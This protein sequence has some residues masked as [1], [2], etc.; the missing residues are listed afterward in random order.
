MKKILFLLLVILVAS[1]SSEKHF[2]TDPT[3]REKV[4]SD[5]NKRKT[6]FTKGAIFDVFNTPMTTEEREAMEFLYAYMPIGDYADYSGDLFLSGVRSALKTRSEVAWGKD[7]PEEVF[8]HFVLPIRANNEHLDSA[9]T[10]FYGELIDKV[11]SLPIEEAALEV[12]RWCHTKVTYRPSDS[13]TSSPLASMKTAHG[14]CGE[15]SVFAVAAMRAVGIPARQVY[16]PRWAHTDDNHAWIEV[17][18][19]DGSWKYMGACEPEPKLNMGWFSDPV[20]RGMLMHTKA[21]GN[22]FG[23]EEFISSSPCF[24][25]VN[26]TENYAPTAVAKVVVKNSDGSVCEGA[27]VMF[28]IYNYAEFY[29]SIRRI[30]DATGS[31]TAV[32]GC[33]DLYAYAEKDGMFGDA[34]ISVS[35][36]TLVEVILTHKNG[37]IFAQNM[38]IVPPVGGTRTV[39]VTDEEREQNNKGLDAENKIRSD[40]EATFMSEDAARKLASDLS[41]DTEKVLLYIRESRGNW[42]TIENFLRQ[43]SAEKRPLAMALLSSLAMKDL[44]DITPE[45]LNDSFVAGDITK[46]GDPIYV[47]NVLNPRVKM[48]MLTPYKEFFAK[49]KITIDSIKNITINN[50]DNS[51]HIAMNP[52]GTWRIGVADDASRDVLY[53][54][55]CRANGTP[56]RVDYLTGKVQYHDGSRWIDVNSDSDEQRVAKTG[57]LKIDYI[58]GA[59]VDDPAYDRHFTIKRFDGK[60]FKLL[61]FR[62][63]DGTEGTCTML[64]LFTKGQELEEGYYLLTTG[65]RMA[66]GKALVAMQTFNIKE[67][68]ITVVKATMREDKSDI[69]VIGALDAEAKF[70]KEGDS[71][72]STILNTTGRGYFVLGVIRSRHEPTTHTIR[73]FVRNAAAF[74]KWGRKMILLFESEKDFNAFNKTEYGTLPSNIVFGVDKGGEITKMLTEGAKISNATAR[75]IFVIADTFGRIVYSTSGYSIGVGEQMLTTINKL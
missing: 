75:P 31:A 39:T 4:N 12:N 22:Y 1:C 68:E 34:K 58:K 43:A 49:E 62:S 44:R 56:A 51:Y 37:E 3:Y 57:T 33:G 41:L 8:R 70:M 14:R 74:E 65:T 30:T 18:T 24:T 61:N 50:A 73:D 71:E 23:K 28:G 67:G 59:G 19:P 40:Y 6:D 60:E 45:V 35:K 52:I 25:E 69:Q 48:E 53:V 29:T 64:T 20:Q 66:S 7:I 17:W 42:Q 38:D 47:E 10:V 5:F 32:T 26:S 16:T 55:I 46:I 27:N 36:D 2:I 63:A 15:E 13:R 21:Y 72:P 9:R 11:K 54:A